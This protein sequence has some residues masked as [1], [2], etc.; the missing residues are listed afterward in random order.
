L[1][2]SHDAAISGASSTNSG[3]W[4]VWRSEAFHL[5]PQQQE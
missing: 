3:A 1:T 4:S 2:A 5:D